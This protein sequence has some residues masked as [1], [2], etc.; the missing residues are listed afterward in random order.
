M[1]I[2][3]I[4][5]ISKE[6]FAEKKDKWV[7]LTTAV[8]VSDY[9]KGQFPDKNLS[10]K[11]YY[12]LRYQI[13][14]DGDPCH[15]TALYLGKVV[16][17]TVLMSEGVDSKMSTVNTDF[18]KYHKV[19]ITINDQPEVRFLHEKCLKYFTWYYTD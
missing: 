14:N 8:E 11:T 16:T 4:G 3:Q 13:L 15:C 17:P 1:R 18:W 10:G 7:Y 9:W 12:D 19:L 5:I 6:F 2:G